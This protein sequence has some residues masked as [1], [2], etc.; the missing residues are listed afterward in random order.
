MS[1]IVAV[2]FL[3]ERGW[4]VRSYYP[5]SI[6]HEPFGLAVISPGLAPCRSLREALG[7]EER[8]WG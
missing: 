1:G 7:L 6:I 8:T 5:S 2:Y 3:P 4:I